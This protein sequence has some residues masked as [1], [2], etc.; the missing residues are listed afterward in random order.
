MCHLGGGGALIRVD[1]VRV[2]LLQCLHG[3]SAG[4]GS[5]RLRDERGAHRPSLWLTIGDFPIWSLND[6]YVRAG[7]KATIGE[8][9]V[10]SDDVTRIF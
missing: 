8:S 7:D 10:D 5:D 6:G 3:F 4:C 2:Y 9:A 1:M